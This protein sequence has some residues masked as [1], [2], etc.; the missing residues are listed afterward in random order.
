MTEAQRQLNAVERRHRALDLYLGGKNQYEIARVLG[1]NQGTVSRTLR[2][3]RKAWLASITDR[4]A[5]AKVEELARLDRLERE[6]LDAWERSKQN[7]EVLTAKVKGRGDTET[8][9]RSEGQVGDPR[10]LAEARACVELR[11]KVLDLMPKTTNVKVSGDPENPIRHEHVMTQE[12]RINRVLELQAK[13]RA[14]L[15]TPR[16]ALETPGEN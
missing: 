2:A 13:A 7:A 11:L 6:A 16:E 15:P 3:A 5:R 4:L 1:V 10:F 8:S 12:Q 14:A 9:K